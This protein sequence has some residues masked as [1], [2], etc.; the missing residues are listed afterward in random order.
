MTKL[1]SL[2]MAVVIAMTAAVAFA[3]L[4]AFDVE[5]VSN[6]VVLDPRADK[7]PYGD[8]IQLINFTDDTNAI[9][10]IY[11]YSKKDGWVLITKTAPQTF[12]DSVL[13]DTSY[14]HKLTKFTAFAIAAENGKTYK[15][16]FSKFIINMYVVKHAVGAIRISPETA[17]PSAKAYSFESASVKGSFKDRIKIEGDE[18][19]VDGKSFVVYGSDDNE[20]WC[21]VAGGTIKKESGY[22]EAVNEDKVAKYKFYAIENREKENFNY[23]VSKSHNDLYFTVTK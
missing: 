11:G 23:A 10:D 1:K 12:G 14:D 7:K 3:D 19:V 15:Y 13:L 18:A 2:V 20:N 9:F 21:V 17:A 8:Y 22:L 6:A 5:G 16:S 4:P